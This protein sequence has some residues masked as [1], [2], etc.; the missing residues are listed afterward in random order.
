MFKTLPI[1]VLAVLCL[2]F[3]ALPQQPK[4]NQAIDVT[5]KGIQVGE[6]LPETDALSKYKGKLIILDFWA[7]WCSP[8]VAMIPKM[9]KLQEQFK[10]QIQIIPVTYQNEEIVDP[11]LKN[12]HKGKVSNLPQITGDKELHKL[13]PHIYL[14]HYVWI[15][16]TGTVKAITGLEEI[17]AENIQKMLHA[18]K[19][20]SNPTAQNASPLKQKRDMKIAYDKSKPYLI[21]GNGGDG[22]TLMYHSVLS[23]YQE[24]LP[25]GWSVYHADSLKYGRITATN[26][27]L[28]SLYQLAF[29][30][31]GYF[32]SNRRI[33]MVRDSL[34][35]SP[36]RPE[37]REAW[38]YNNC[39]NYELIVPPALFASRFLIMR[40]D[41][42][43]ILYQY[44]ARIEKRMT[45]CLA[46][47]RT[48]REDK[49]RSASSKTVFR[50]DRFGME[51]QHM[52]IG[53]FITQLN[54][55]SLQNSKIPVVDDTG[56]T[57][58]VDLSIQAKLN[59]VESINKA[60]EAYD[61]KFVVKECLIDMLVI[62][63]SE[64]HTPNH[65]K[66]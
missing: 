24:G 27:R 10:A 41:M 35:F 7:T 36:N 66:I 6:K 15:D 58:R 50:A 62:R 11:F 4:T 23:R 43:R 16:Q 37:S 49:I 25:Y 32:V 39:Y 26:L 60:L 59:D 17:T 53:R 29:W 34:P 51:M 45:S 65:S 1:L 61:L 22:N 47:V 56:Y 8:C 20:S 64:N 48:S 31:Q 18:S 30:D 38:Q 33:L 28:A 57:G 12:L 55:Q 40:G 42:D 63:D 19:V 5:T 14:P 46:L 52:P 13:F 9:E 2:N 54:A 3:A 21:N 44:E